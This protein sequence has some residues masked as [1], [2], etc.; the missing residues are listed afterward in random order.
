MRSKKSKTPKPPKVRLATPA[1][2]P[3]QLRYTCPVE[4]R[5]I[6]VTT[7]TYDTAEA[8]RQKAELEAKLLLG[9]PRPHQR[10]TAAG[11]HMAWEVFRERYAEIQLTALREKSAADAESRLN[12]AE[13]ILKPRTLSD[14][15][16]GDALHKLQ[17]RLLAGEA[18]KFDRQRS[19]HTVKGYMS[20]TLAALNWA[21][22]MEWLP[23]VPR[24]R[25]LK[26]SNLK[27]MKG[28]PLA[29][30]EFERM[31]AVVP[32]VVGVAA[33][34]SWRYLLYGLWESGLR[35]GELMHVSWDDSNMVRPHW[36]RRGDP[37]LMIPHAMQKNDTEEAIPLLPGFESLLLETTE[38]Q[39]SGWVFNPAP[40]HTR[41]GRPV[42]R[43]R[44]SPGWVSRV[45]C[46][47]GKKAGV[48]VTPADPVRKT[49][50]K[51]ASSHDLR[52]SCA[53]RLDD[54]GVPEIDIMR[55]MRHRKR[56]T[57]RRHYAPGTV[58]K[59]AQRI[60]AYL[61]TV[62]IAAAKGKSRDGDAT[63]CEV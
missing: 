41:I 32:K 27:H 61:G 40:L 42:R 18:S 58:Q 30:E 46:H 8:E 45:V 35:L 51:F 9:I 54:A 2:R 34:E 52:R 16:N 31:L 55:V 22:Y 14:V 17:A 49:K 63:H 33:A 48:V 37:L 15:A 23:A 36:P 50:A 53:Q 5:E 11:P 6:R 60:R 20:A 62:S 1:N 47:I 12:V 13:R 29:L 28:R 57:L 3:I 10:K 4:K 26:V 24:I 38:D 19:P 44:L 56:E 59:S 39:R 7:G 43:E 21:V 25:R